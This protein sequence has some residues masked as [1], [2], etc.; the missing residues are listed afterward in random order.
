MEYGPA[1]WYCSWLIWFTVPY[2]DGNL[3]EIWW[4]DTFPP[5]IM[6][7]TAICL[8]HRVS[9]EGVPML[10]HNDVYGH[11]LTDVSH[12]DLQCYKAI[13]SVVFISDFI[14]VWLTL[15]M[16]CFFKCVYFRM[17]VAIHL[18]MCNWWRDTQRY[19]WISLQHRTLW[20][21]PAHTSVTKI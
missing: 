20:Y 11:T 14:T 3:A 2:F 10:W 17:W 13:P 21:R 9:N 1:I 19:S 16:W 6:M 8:S 7:F 15:V 12:L 18:F 5:Q 4:L